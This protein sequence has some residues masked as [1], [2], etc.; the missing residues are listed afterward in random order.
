M[1]E[2]WLRLQDRPG[3]GFEPQNELYAVM[4]TLA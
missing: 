3:I 1:E 4:R 2:G